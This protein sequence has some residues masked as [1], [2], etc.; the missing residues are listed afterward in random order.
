MAQAT[1]NLSLSQY[2]KQFLQ[3][4][5]P[6]CVFADKESKAYKAMESENRKNTF[7]QTVRDKETEIS[8]KLIMHEIVTDLNLSDGYGNTA[9]HYSCYFGHYLILRF[10]LSCL[11]KDISPISLWAMNTVGASPLHLASEMKQLLCV[12]MILESIKMRPSL[13]QINQCNI[14]G[15]NA[16]HYVCS[17]RD[18]NNNIGLTL[19]NCNEI[20]ELLIKAGI[21]ITIKTKTEKTALDIWNESCE[22]TFSLTDTDDKTA[23]WKSQIVA[24]QKLLGAKQTNDNETT[25]E[26]ESKQ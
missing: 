2:A 25:E 18:V 14:N 26:K 16:L 6:G 1:S 11:E 3:E 8:L 12:K 24:I 23:I 5:F 10:L 21:D 4:N 17:L 9:L 22:K 13:K 20:I 7:L 19:N 15:W